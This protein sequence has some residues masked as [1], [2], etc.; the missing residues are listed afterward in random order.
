MTDVK[1]GPYVDEDGEAVYF[2]VN[3]YTY[4]EARAAASAFAEE[5]D[6]PWG[7]SRYTGKHLRGLHDHE[8]PWGGADDECGAEMTWCFDLYE[9]SYRG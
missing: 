2:P 9:G 8:E 3:G 4:N 7:R 1:R 6:G 5:M